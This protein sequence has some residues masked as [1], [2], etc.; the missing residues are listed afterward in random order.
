MPL[1]NGFLKGLGRF[2]VLVLLSAPWIACVL[3]LDFGENIWLNMLRYAVP[4]FLWN[5]TLTFLLD[6][7]CFKLKLYD[8][9]IERASAKAF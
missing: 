3:L 4:F 8:P 6:I 1:T 5:A 2:V 9:F 7:I